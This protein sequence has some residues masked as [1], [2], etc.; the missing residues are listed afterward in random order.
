MTEL[1]NKYLS[2]LSNLNSGQDLNDSSIQFIHDEL[3]VNDFTIMHHR[4]HPQPYEIIYSGKNKIDL[5]EIQKEILKSV[6]EH[7]FV[8]KI[9]TKKY[10]F[11]FFDS[12]ITTGTGNFY[13]SEH[14]IKNNIE[15]VL[16]LW[17]QQ[18]NIIKQAIGNKEI[19]MNEQQAGL[20]S[21]LMHDIQAIINLTSSVEKS[22]QLLQRIEYQKKVN[23]NYLFWVRECE[24][25]KTKV[26]IK[27]LLESSLQIAGIESSIIDLD[28]PAN[29]IDISVDVELFAMA[30]NSIVQNAIEAVEKNLSKVTINVSQYSPVSPFFRKNWTIIQV[31][32]R[33]FG[34]KEDF[35]PL[36]MY[37]F[38]TTKKEN[39]FSGFGLANAKKIIET[40]QGCIEL[41][42][43]PGR[44][45]NVII[46]IPG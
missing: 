30:F 14:P 45:T 27:E 24:L 15:S 17:N 18:E 34:I 10:N 36:V 33:G 2:F 3:H 9:K 4:T 20:A 37:P 7:F 21:Q 12:I 23:K 42:S 38:F 5:D 26:V 39:G 1:E 40:H 46:M 13:L 43:T 8:N 6:D 19:Q 29:C 31:A 28:I 25:M 22:D 11:F 44:G 41:K 32:D 16:R 35:I